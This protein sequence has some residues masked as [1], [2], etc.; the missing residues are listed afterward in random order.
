M[1]TPVAGI[2]DWQPAATKTWVERPWAWPQRSEIR[3][4]WGRLFTEEPLMSRLHRLRGSGGNL[5]QVIRGVLAASLAVMILGVGAPTH[6]GFVITP[7]FD[8][9]ITTDPNAAAIEGVINTA[10]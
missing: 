10:I 3:R 9:S 6:A 5:R 2:F 7:H 8:S 1:Q 4:H